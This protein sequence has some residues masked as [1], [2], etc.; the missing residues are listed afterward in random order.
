MS[1]VLMSGNEAIVEGAVRAGLKFYPSYPITPASDIMLFVL[2]KDV[3]FMQAEDE[4]AAINM[5]IGA[6][7]AGVKSMTGTSGPGFSLMQEGIGYAYVVEAPL[8]IINNQRVGPSTGMPTVGSQGDILQAKHG[9]HGDY[10]SLVF[11]P[12]SVAELYKTTIH[13][14]NASEEARMPV[15]LLSDG[16]LS[17]MAE[18]IDFEKLKA[19]KIELKKRAIEPLGNLKRHFTGLYSKNGIPDTK[20]SENY[21]EWYWN[22]KK[23]ISD[24]IKKYNFYEFYGNKDSDTLLIA[25]GITSRV[26]SEL[27]DEFAIFRPI[28]LFPILDELKEAAKNYEKIVVIEMNDGQYRGEVEGFLKRDVECISLLGGKISIEEVKD[29]LKKIC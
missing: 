8:L 7:L 19:E 29:E 16:T 26:V 27:K 10:Q 25:Y 1:N 21:R 11:Y 13:A 3:K 6:S 20:N 28:R 4:I 18:S 14:I 15:I 24:I 2:K 5:C 9:S 17:R 22:R 12:N 23:Q